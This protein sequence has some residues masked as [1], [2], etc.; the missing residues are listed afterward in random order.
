MQSKCYK[1]LV[2][3]P[4][5]FKNCTGQLIIISHIF[6]YKIIHI[7]TTNYCVFWFIKLTENVS[8]KENDKLNSFLKVQK[9]SLMF[10]QENLILTNARY[11]S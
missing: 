4:M 7:T 6:W 1:V 9:F 10:S 2:C 3:F 5:Y 11:I 8:E